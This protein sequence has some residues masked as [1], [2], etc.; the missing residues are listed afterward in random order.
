M[1]KYKTLKRVLASVMTLVML[2]TAELPLIWQT[3]TPA[4]TAAAAEIEQD[5]S[6]TPAQMLG[7]NTD[8]APDGFDENDEFTNPYGKRDV[9][10]NAANEVYVQHMGGDE[11]GY[12]IGDG[13]SN[14]GSKYTDKMGK[15][16]FTYYDGWTNEYESDWGDREGWYDDDWTDIALIVADNASDQSNLYDSVKSS[17]MNADN[18]SSL[19]RMVQLNTGTNGKAIGV[20]LIRRGDYYG[21]PSANKPIRDI[22][23]FEFP[24]SQYGNSIP[25]ETIEAED[26]IWKRVPV[27]T[28]DGMTEADAEYGE[29]NAGATRKPVSGKLSRYYMYYTLDADR[30][31]PK[32]RVHRFVTFKQLSQYS[33]PQGTMIEGKNGWQYSD[34]PVNLNNYTDGEAIYFSPYFQH[35]YDAGI[36]EGSRVHGMAKIQEN[37]YLNK[38]AAGNFDGNGDLKKYQFAMVAYDGENL[39]LGVVDSRHPGTS[40]NYMTLGAVDKSTLPDNLTGANL[41]YASQIIGINSMEIVTGDFDGNGI[42]D[43][44]VYNPDSAAGERV[45]IYAKTLSG[46]P[47]DIDTWELK[48]SISTDGFVTLTAGD[49]N[50]DGI[51]DLLVGDKYAAVYH[52]AR[53]NMLNKRVALSVPLFKQDY[54]SYT[55]VKG[56][57]AV[58]SFTENGTTYLAV[59]NSPNHCY[60]HA[61]FSGYQSYTG[62]SICIFKSNG[63]NGYEVVTSAHNGIIGSSGKLEGVP[64][65][66]TLYYANGMLTT[67]ALSY[68]LGIVDE[69][70]ITRYKVDLDP[71][72]GE[73]ILSNFE[74]PLARVITVNDSYTKMGDDDNHVRDKSLNKNEWQEFVKTI[75]ARTPKQTYGPKT[76]VSTTDY[77]YF[78]YDFQVAYLNGET[79]KETVFFKA[80]EIA[81]GQIYYYQYAMTPYFDADGNLQFD[82][83]ISIANNCSAKEGTTDQGYH[84]STRDP[85]TPTCFAVVDTDDDAFFLHYTGKHWFEYTDPQVLAVLAAPPAFKDLVEQDGLSGGY[86]GSSTSFGKSH[87][88]SDSSSYSNTVSAGAY[89]S[90][91]QSIEV[92]GIE[93]ASYEMELS[94]KYSHTWTDSHT[95]S[96]EYSAEYST[97][98]GADAIVFYSIPYEFYEYEVIGQDKNGEK[99][100]IKRTM[101]FPK[102]PCMTTMELDKYRRLSENCSGLPQIPAD[103]LK[104]TVGEPASYPKSTNGYRNVRVYD[105]PYMAVDFTSANS[106]S[107]SQTIEMS[108]EDESAYSNSVEVE[109]KVGGGSGGVKVGISAGYEY[110]ASFAHTSTSGHSFTATME[111]MP[112]EAERYGYGMSWKLFSHENSYVDSNGK[113]INFFVVDYLVNDVMQPPMLPANFRQ[114]YERTTTG[115]VALKW[116]YN[117]DPAKVSS[118]TYF[119]VYRIT[120]I[121]GREIQTLIGKVNYN[122][123]LST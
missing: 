110:E 78:P 45:Q 77:Y 49:F 91:E 1:K 107:Q 24:D 121:G 21:G 82:F 3:V 35:D 33:N 39:L 18:K 5:G 95:D 53:Q 62:H 9:V 75:P 36:V 37:P 111:N 68:E 98:V 4:I 103:T 92:F 17:Y 120:N 23:V 97:G 59:G 11:T 56:T 76:T 72:S 10:M 66:M 8:A 22:R 71:L 27:Y 88:S 50:G 106:M 105:G 16:A 114:D 73:P 93:I 43:I 90:Y 57:Y 41:T 55:E 40:Q 109:M 28:P 30:N 26:R 85:K 46:A 12:I 118:S 13:V 47:E 116:D 52:G 89:V 69:V 84:S 32:V 29:L 58:T 51:D 102:Q 101:C 2:P 15:K 86:D 115:Q 96:V 42:D 104:H 64:L 63:N 99:A 122:K 108:S 44:A 94:T 38:T 74:L 6:Q 60:L 81:D 87:G 19:N 65:K 100:V 48:R 119:N 7:I 25:P 70:Y 14:V 61:F 117:V 34:T 31:A 113:S 83:G 79:E 123:A 20:T 112:K 80:M 67:G 54:P